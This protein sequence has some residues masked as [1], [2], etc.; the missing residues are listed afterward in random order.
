MAAMI[1]AQRARTSARPGWCSTSRFVS[2][3]EDSRIGRAHA[4]TDEFVTPGRTAIATRAPSLLSIHANA[5]GG[6][7]A[8]GV[9]TCFLSCANSLEAAAAA[10][11]PHPASDGCCPT[12][13]EIALNN[14]LDESRDLATIV[15]RAMIE[16]LRGVNKSLKDLGVKQAPFAVLIGAAM[17]SV[18]AEVS[19]VTNTQDARQLR[20]PAY[21]QRIAEALANAV[22]K[23]QT[24]LKS[25][26]TV[27]FE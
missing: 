9:E 7:I 25:V 19:F 12:S 16:R 17:P 11:T 24:S 4:A 23:Y 5:S 21:R 15:Q 1:R 10:R 8:R 14:K 6:P 22:R 26:S 3:A 27:A 20:A 2:A 18:L 13:S